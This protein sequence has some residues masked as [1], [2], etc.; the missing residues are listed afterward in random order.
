MDTEVLKEQAQIP[1]ISITDFRATK[2][3]ML[4]LLVCFVIWMIIYALINKY[5]DMPEMLIVAQKKAAGDKK[6]L[7]K[8]YKQHRK[9]V[10]STIAMIMSVFTFVFSGYYFLNYGLTV[11]KWNN[12]LEYIQCTVVTSYFLADWVF[13]LKYGQNDIVF[14]AHHILSL[15]IFGMP[16]LYNRLGSESTIG[17]WFGEVSGPFVNLRDIFPL[18]NHITLANTFAFLYSKKNVDAKEQKK[19]ADFI[20]LVNE[21]IFVVTFIIARTYGFGYLVKEISYSQAPLLYKIS[22]NG[23]WFVSMI[24]LWQIAHKMSKILSLEL[25]PNSFIFKKIYQIL[26]T[27]R[28]IQPAF[29]L[30]SAWYTN[31]HT[32]AFHGVYEYFGF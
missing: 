21:L 30:F 10:S 28:P 11:G 9:Y 22:I 20:I 24:W 26:R 2:Q 5:L 3:D 23:M 15:F 29:L 32:L 12:G 31:R 17:I 6:E 19:R 16:I 14:A 1:A 7:H 25:F 13:A 18:I 27:I 8:V 4:G